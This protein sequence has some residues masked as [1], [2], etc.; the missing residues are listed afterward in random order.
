MEGLETIIFD[1]GGVIIDVK[2]DKEWLEEDLLPIF[3]RDQFEQLFTN[4]FF[5]HFETGK[6]SA[7]D[8]IKKLKSIALDQN[9]TSETILIHW[10]ALLKEIPQQRIDL[11]KRLKEKYRLI[12]ISNTDEFHLSAVQQYMRQKFKEDILTNYFHHCYYSFQVGLR[13]PHREIY[14]LVIQH[15]QLHVSNCLFLDDKSANLVEPSK[16]G[17]PTLLIDREVTELLAKY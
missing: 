13:K 17:I 10:N 4:N 7:Q 5:K 3:Q 6:V 12:L 16:L 9:C 15:E 14:D 8:F 1:L 2:S 11:L